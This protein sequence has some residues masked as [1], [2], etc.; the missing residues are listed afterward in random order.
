[1]ITEISISSL[2]L[3]LKC[4]YQKERDYNTLLPDYEEAIAQSMKQPPPP[5]CKVASAMH[6]TSSNLNNNL[7]GLTHITNRQFIENIATSQNSPPAYDESNN[8]HSVTV[9]SDVLQPSNVESHNNAGN[10]INEITT[11]NP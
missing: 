8:Q 6:Q 4:L 7:T 9:N 1:M 10:Q 11:Q 3:I 2:I 5:Y